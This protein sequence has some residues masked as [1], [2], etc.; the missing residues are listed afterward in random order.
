MAV[1][2]RVILHTGRSPSLLKQL[3]KDV[4][5][6][7][8]S[9]AAFDPRSIAPFHGLLLICKDKSGF[10]YAP[11]LDMD[12]ELVYTPFDQWWNGT[13]FARQGQFRMSRADVVLTASNQDGG[14]HVDSALRA[15]YASLRRDN[16]LGW[17]TG[18]G[19]PLPRDPVYA[20]IRQVSH[21]ILKTLMPNYNKTRKDVEDSYKESGLVDGK[22]QFY[23]HQRFFLFLKQLNA[24]VV[25]DRVYVCGITVDSLTTGSVRMVVNSSL[26]DPVTAAGTYRLR[27]AA[28][29]DGPTGFI[30]DY[31]DA[32]ISDLSII[33]S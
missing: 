7:I 12:G 3:G 16:A 22:I 24:P 10:Y 21:E 30:G 29:S 32:V 26:S 15:D 23:P 19:D 1:I 27:V 9:N 25:P 13:V 4:I 33:P 8:D 17:L 6:F 31:T 2:L 28:G 18:R 14:A 5:Q 11:K 20:S